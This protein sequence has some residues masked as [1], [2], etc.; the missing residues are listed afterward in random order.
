M[1]IFD[2][3]A[4][5]MEDENGKEN[6]RNSVP[7]EE[8]HGGFATAEV[9]CRRPFW[10]RFLFPRLDRR[11]LIRLVLVAL[12]AYLF[13]R[14]VCVPAKIH[15]GSMEPTY[16]SSGF[17]F[18]WRPAY[19]LSQPKRGDIVV[20]RYTGAKLYLKRVVGLPG[21]R[22]EF[23]NGAL[24]VNGEELDEPYVVKPSDWNLPE[25]TVPEGKIYVVGD[26]RSMPMERHVFGAVKLER[27]YGS[28]LW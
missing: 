14:F 15:G 5:L 12:V 16:P 6:G 3:L 24:F 18:C 11:F 4:I 1:S 28:T 26:N 17:D 2:S 22:I 7:K 9:K 21:D 19:W 20:L 23:R 8:N 10:R 25:R 27:L 13:F